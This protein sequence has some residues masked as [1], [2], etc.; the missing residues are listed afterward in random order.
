[1]DKLKC[2]RCGKWLCK[3][4][5]SST[6]EIPCPRCNNL[7]IFDRGVITLKPL[8]VKEEKDY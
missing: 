7:V 3:T 6:F 1:M 5:N 2:P 4:E 8:Q